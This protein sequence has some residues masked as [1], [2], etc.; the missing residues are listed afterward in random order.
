LDDGRVPQRSFTVTD[1]VNGTS[2]VDLR[3]NGHVCN[4]ASVDG[5]PIGDPSVHYQSYVIAQNPPHASFV[6]H[7]LANAFGPLTLEVKWATLLMLPAGVAVGSD[8]P[9]PTPGV[10]AFVCYRLEFPAF[11]NFYVDEEDQFTTPPVN[12]KIRK[13]RFLCAAASVDGA[14]VS[15]PEALMICYRHV[16]RLERPRPL[17]VD[18]RGVRVR[19]AFSSVVG[20]AGKDDLICLKTVMLD[21]PPVQ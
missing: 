12:Y 9:P 18:V 6:E 13:P 20:T 16:R 3:L 17:D 11:P 4:A 19:T 21:P 5:S 1:A 8:P 14:P 15:N 2:Q 7:H 10:D